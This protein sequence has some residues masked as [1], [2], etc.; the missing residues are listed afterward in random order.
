MNYLSF[1]ESEEFTIALLIKYS[2]FIEYELK[3]N[4]V[5]PLTKEGV[6]A[7]EIMAAPLLYNPQGKIPIGYARDQLADMLPELTAMGV[8]TIYVA[9]AAYFKALTKQTKAEPHLGYILPCKIEGYEHM[10][11]IYGVNHHSIVYNPSNQDKLDQSLSTLTKHVQGQYTELGKDIIEYEEYPDNARD[12]RSCLKELLR[13]PELFIDI[14]AFS[15]RKTE[16]GIGSIAFAWSKNKG[17]AFCCDYAEVSVNDDSNDYGEFKPNEAVRRLL[18]E[19]FQKYPGKVYWHGGNYD[20]GVII[21]TLWM[22]HLTDYAGLLEGLEIMCPEGKWHDTRLIAFLALNSCARQEYGLKALSHSYAGNYAVD[23]TDIKKVPRSKLLRYNLIDALCTAYVRDT[24]WPKLAARKQEALYKE[25]FIPA[26]KT[27][28][29]MELVGL[30]IYSNKVKELETLL[31]NE[32]SEAEAKIKKHPAY[33]EAT[34]I[35]RCRLAEAANKKLKKLRKTEEDFADEDLNINSSTQLALLLYEVLGL[36]VIDTTDTGQPATGQKTVSKLKNHTSDTEVLEIL[37]SIEDFS[38]A[39]KIHSS[40]LPAFKS[41][42][43]LNDAVGLLQGSFMLGGTKSGRMS[44]NS[45]NMQQIPSGSKFGKPVKECFGGMNGWLLVGADFNALEARIGAL[46]TK[47][48]N[49]LAIYTEGYDSHCFNT[50]SYWPDQCIGIVRTPESINSIA[51]K[52]SKLRSKSK[53]ITFAAQYGGTFHTFMNSGGF[54]EQEAKQIEANYKETYK[55]SEEWVEKLLDRVRNQGYTDI[56]FGLRLDAPLL[57]RS[58]KG[59]K[60]GGGIASESRTIGNASQQS[61]GLLTNRA[62]NGFMAKVWGHEEMRLKVMPVAMIHDALYFLVKNEPLTV[63]WVNDHLIEEME[64][65]ELPE[66]QHDTVKLGA[67][68]EIFYPNWA[69][70][71]SIPNNCSAHEIVRLCAAHMEKLND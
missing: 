28:I 26:Q 18:K 30:P 57:A 48:P 70:P 54:S 33:A 44:S 69:K 61:Y 56:A 63:K 21:S 32:L 47:D 6:N 25:M 34:F 20:I 49:K 10:E 39:S 19:F 36:P 35:H 46:V 4:Y 16:A 60:S 24:Y 66:I 58:I 1:G 64:W 12:I 31:E 51:D 59:I 45:P 40:F 38:K 65:N 41:A 62:M 71:V 17:A 9:D 55:V 53:T 29:Q 68:L 5:I 8:T 7:D 37:D 22:D 23:V 52:Y 67:E 50:F 2:A 11:V 15:L 27:V 13:Y 3:Q 42:P 43:K 14:E